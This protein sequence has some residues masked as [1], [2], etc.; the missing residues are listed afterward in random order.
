MN[1]E[2]IWKDIV[3]YEGLYK[4][5]NKGGVYSIR[6]K[7]EMSP[8]ISNNGYKRVKLY[9]RGKYK[10]ISIHRLV[11]KTFLENPENYP[12]VNHIDE[13]KFN[14]NVE[15]LEWCTQKQNVNHGTGKQRRAEAVKMQVEQYTL[16]NQYIATYKS[17]VDLQKE[18]GFHQSAISRVC[19]GERKSAYKYIWRYVG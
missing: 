9:T 5:S 6:R 19:R 16:D 10:T 7:R 4:V 13:N 14:N 17:A 2:V 15:N 18:Y 1:N 11:A 8:T 12:V 3:G